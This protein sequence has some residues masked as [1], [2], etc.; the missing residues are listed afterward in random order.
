[1]NTLKLA[2][3]R[4]GKEIA[5]QAKVNKPVLFEI[6]GLGVFH[7]RNKIAAVDFD[8]FLKGDVKVIIVIMKEYHV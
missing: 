5:F 8:I 1:M 2:V 7:L 3:S 4:L 6:P